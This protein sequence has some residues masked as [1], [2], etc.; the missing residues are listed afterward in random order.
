MSC[1]LCPVTESVREAVG[2]GVKIVLK[3]GVQLEVRDKVENRV[4]VSPGSKHCFHPEVSHG[5]VLVLV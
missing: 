2:R 1:C 5:L 3:L 4:L